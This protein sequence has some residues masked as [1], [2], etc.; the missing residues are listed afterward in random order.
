MSI[1]TATETTI[2]ETT[3]ADL[4]Q[5]EEGVTLNTT[6]ADLIRMGSETTTQAMGWG[7]AATACALSAAG[8]AAERAGLI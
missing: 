8:Q 2:D 3:A 7:S 6:L 1:D 4:A 5:I